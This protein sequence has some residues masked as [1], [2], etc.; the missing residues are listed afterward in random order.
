MVAWDAGASADRAGLEA[1]DLIIAFNE[2]PLRTVHEL[3][4]RLVHVETGKREE[5]SFLRR[6]KR[7]TRAIVPDERQKG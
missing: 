2:Q 5:I 7:L 3:H 1:G 4:K 6:G